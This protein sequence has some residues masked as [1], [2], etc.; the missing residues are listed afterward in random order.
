MAKNE[1]HRV[2]DKDSL[3]EG[4]VTTVT[5]GIKT[6]CLAHFDGNYYALDNHCPHQ[7]GPLGEGQIENGFVVCPWHGYEYKPQDGTPPGGYDDAVETYSL[8]I[9]DDG[10]YVAVEPEKHPYTI[11]HQMMEVAVEWGLTHIFGMVGHSNLGLAE[12]IRAQEEKGKITFIGVRHE[13]AA[14]F[15]ASAFAKLTGKPAA[16]LGIAGPGSTNLLT[17]LWDAKVD[18]AP[19]L[20]LSGQVNTQ[21][22][23]PGAFQEIDLASAFNSV[24]DFSQTVLG[25]K[26]ASDLMALA[27]KHAIITRDVA[28]LIFPDEIQVAPGLEKPPQTPKQGRVSTTQITPPVAELNEAIQL[29]RDAKIVSIIVGH[30]ARFHKEK[31]IKLAETLQAPIITTFK[32]KG[33]VS[34]SHPLACGVLGR[35][36][37]PVGSSMMGRADVLLVLGASFSNH[38]GISTKKKLIQ[39]DYDRMTLGKFHAVDVPLWGDIGVT[40]DL[41]TEAFSETQFQR[42]FIPKEIAA[43]WSRWRA[44]KQS[45]AADSQSDGLNSAF[46]FHHLSEIVPENAVLAVDVGNNTY[47]FGRYFETKQGQDVLMSGYLGSI[48]F[49]MPAAIGAW[50]ATPDRPIIAVAGDGGFGQY[51]MEFTT[52]VKYNIPVRLILLN[53]SELGKISKEQR[54][55]EWQ[56]WQTSLVNPNFAEFAQSSGGWGKRVT[57]PNQLHD[58]LTEAFAQPGPALVEIIT[59]PLKI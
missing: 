42:D 46:L 53:N 51:A 32:A 15:A 47:S 13:G 20:A 54:S 40:A 6:I 41:L 57:D 3:P 37:T 17:G 1:W 39:V 45:R 29:I 38:T 34:D 52:A 11:S 23:G 8:D 18:R 26:N 25:A 48:G 28:H 12:A 14:A 9:R 58:I 24:A 7:G 59:D 31:V 56:V 22:L 50:A 19:I 2:A 33:L 4:R 21:V 44:E 27:L 43:R 10:I 30:G 5:A 35:S 49:A 36:G 55:G 16:C